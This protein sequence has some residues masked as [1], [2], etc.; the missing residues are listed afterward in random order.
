MLSIMR[1]HAQSWII[2]AVLGLMVIVFV[3]WGVGSFRSERASRVAQVNGETISVGEYQQT[4]RQTLDRIKDVYGQQLDEKTMYSPEFKKKVLD[5]LIE[6]R[7]IL[8]DGKGPGVFGNL[9]RAV[10]GHPADALFPGE[11]EVQSWSN[12]KEF[13]R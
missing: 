12:T 2:K 8:E 5:G 10:P 9:R 4:Y 13:F 6:K 3:F 1:K 11:R 7:L